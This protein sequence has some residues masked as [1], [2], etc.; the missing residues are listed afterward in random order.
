MHRSCDWENQTH[1]YEPNTGIAVHNDELEPV[2]A[3]QAAHDRM[4]LRKYAQEMEKKWWEA[5]QQVRALETTNEKIR[6]EL[7]ELWDRNKALEIS[8]RRSIDEKKLWQRV[9]HT[10]VR[11]VGGILE[12]RM[13]PYALNESLP[14]LSGHLH[15]ALWEIIIPYEEPEELP[16]P[17]GKGTPWGQVTQ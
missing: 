15:H 4:Q 13:M 16:R 11:V 5:K 7:G 17:S 1:H 2:N 14:K 6:K 12:T 8:T 9:V 3:S 10:C